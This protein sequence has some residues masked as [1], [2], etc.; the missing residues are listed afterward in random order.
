MRPP[1]EH[2][3]HP[4]N[5]LGRNDQ[6]ELERSKERKQGTFHPAGVNIVRPLVKGGV[7]G[8][9]GYWTDSM[10]ENWYPMHPRGPPRKVIMLLHTPGFWEMASGGDSQ[11]SGLSSIRT[12]IDQFR[13]AIGPD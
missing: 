3:V 7:G 6:A 8:E 2:V 9:E 1:N 13:A 12:G 4:D 5:I 11:R 10:I